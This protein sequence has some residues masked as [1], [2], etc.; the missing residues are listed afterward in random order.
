MACLNYTPTAALI[1]SFT[2]VQALL[3]R[4]R[5]AFVFYDPEALKIKGRE[6]IAVAEIEAAFD[7]PNLTV[8]A[9]PEQLHQAL[10]ERNYRQSVL[11]M[12]SSGNYGGLD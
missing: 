8:F 3:E 7:H 5:A 1:L 11:L 12:M 4:T 6:P 2:P 10:F 9:Q